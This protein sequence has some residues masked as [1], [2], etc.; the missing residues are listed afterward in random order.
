MTRQTLMQVIL[1]AF[2]HSSTVGIVTAAP[3]QISAGSNSTCHIDANS[4]LTC[5][6]NNSFG[7]LGIGNFVPFP[8][9]RVVAFFTSVTAISVGDGFACAISSGAVFCWGKNDLGQ[10]GNGT[11]TL[12]NAP[13]PVIGL[14]ANVTAVAAGGSH[15]CAVQNFLIKCWGNNSHG[16]L[17]LGPFTGIGDF[18]KEPKQTFGPFGAVSSVTISAG[19]EHTCATAIVD[20][21][22]K[23]FCWGFNNLHQAG[24]A[25]ETQDF[26][27]PTE[28]KRPP[29]KFAPF[30]VAAG[31]RHTCG[32]YR[33][34][35][36]S[37]VYC[38]GSNSFG[39]LG[40]GH[41][42]P[43]GDCFQP[44]LPVIDNT[45]SVATGPTSNHTCSLANDGK[46]HCWGSNEFGQIGNNTQTNQ[47]KAT[48]PLGMNNRVTM[49]SV[50]ENYTCSLALRPLSIIRR[51]P[52][53]A[54]R[55]RLLL[56]LHAFCWGQNTDGQ[57][58]VRDFKS[59]LAPTSVFGF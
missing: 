59:R 32:V 43:C 25:N 51:R 44:T 6:G 42:Q 24:Q 8:N 11:T 14:S 37:R 23:L 20:R 33:Q 1:I 49:I 34:L 38:W 5:W 54:V 36:E 39:Q 27:S 2:L 57:L 56:T 9:P 53:T 29:G 46:M 47:F 26:V 19:E 15:A 10:L 50:G 4:R 58:G 40:L 22:R 30:S 28:V 17:G 45:A 7:Q 12:S 55:G 16:Q 18:Q 52:L 13:T 21:S 3:R 35:T 31:R 41:K 48:V